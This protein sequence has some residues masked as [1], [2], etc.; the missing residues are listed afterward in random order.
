[1]VLIFRTFVIIVVE[2]L[3]D[4]E[5][6]YGRVPVKD[7]MNFLGHDFGRDRVITI[8]ISII[9]VYIHILNQ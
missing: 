6:D 4:L 9:N 7:I 8:R 5:E 1:M 2:F 3:K